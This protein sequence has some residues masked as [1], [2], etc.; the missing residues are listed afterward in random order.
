MSKQK[1]PYILG[2]IA[3][4]IFGLSFVF[5]KNA[6]EEADPFVILAFRFLIAFIIFTVLI[7]LKIVKVN[8]KNKPL[9]PLIILGLITPVIDLGAETSALNYIT[10]IEA[11]LFLSLVPI[12]VLILSTIFLKEDITPKKIIFVI[13]SVIGAIISIDITKDSLNSSYFGTLLIVIGVL[14]CA[15]YSIVSRKLSNKYTPAEITYAMIT[16]GMIT[17]F[18][19]AVLTKKDTMYNTFYK[20][21]FNKQFVTSF[22]YLAIG[23]SI[24]AFFIYNYMYS[25]ISAITTSVYTNL[26]TVITIIAGI[27][28][29]N[30]KISTNQ[31]IG[32]T[33]IIIGVLGTNIVEYKTQNKCSKPTFK[34]KIK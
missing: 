25:Q 13:I 34:T 3:S 22:L 5:V 23:C 20:I 15:T 9:W 2:I 4:T 30:E 27:V 19:L 16:V 18:I 6:L 11:A 17:F 26:I 29:L 32:G 24:I 14:G 21:L 8:Y 31:V 7:L 1:L 33:L 10:T 28:I 12:I